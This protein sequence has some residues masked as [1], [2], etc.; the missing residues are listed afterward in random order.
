MIKHI[1]IFVFLICGVFPF[2]SKYQKYTVPTQQYQHNVKRTQRRKHLT[3]NTYSF[4]FCTWVIMLLWKY[5]GL[6]LLQLFLFSLTI[7]PI[8]FNLFLSFCQSFLQF[9]SSEKRKKKHNLVKFL[10]KQSLQLYKTTG[11]YLQ[12]P[13]CYEHIRLTTTMYNEAKRLSWMI[14]G[15]L[16]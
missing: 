1:E 12:I 4:K 7:T 6:Q 16:R 8:L 14:K 2:T 11:Q 10:T 9:T 15:Y 3:K 13:T 5:L